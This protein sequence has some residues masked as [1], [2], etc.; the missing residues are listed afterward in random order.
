MSAV[1]RR[2]ADCRF[3]QLMIREINP[4]RGVPLV[5]L[6]ATAYSSRSFLPLMA[7][8]GDRR[9]VIAVDAPGYGESDGPSSPIPVAT[10][11]ECIGEALQ[12]N[13]FD[14]FGYHTGVV[15]GTELAI[16]GPEQVTRLTLMGIPY[17]KVLDFEAWKT[18]LAGSHSLAEDL[19][20]F[21]ERWQWLVTDRPDGMSLERAFSNFVDELRSW[22][23]GSWAHQAMFDYDLDERFPLVRQPV[24]VLNPESH[25]S[26]P[27]RTAARLFADATCMELPDLSGAVLEKHADAIVDL[28]G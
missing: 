4:G 23:N 10:Y 8:Y 21:D 5:C 17:F 25:L 1:R 26:A 16:Q 19:S 2:L 7:A 22:P 13:E 12:L 15:M 6:H 9:H 27:S 18:R 14:V 28:I 3:G 11:A 20:Q 24:K